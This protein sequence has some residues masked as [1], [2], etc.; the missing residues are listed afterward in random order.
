LVSNIS[1]ERISLE[2]NTPIAEQEKLWKLIK[3]HGNIFKQQ[4]KFEENKNKLKPA[5]IQIQAN[6]QP[7]IERMGQM[8]PG[9]VEL[10]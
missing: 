3:E 2:K 9:E 8:N 5:S 4:I 1:N 7:I 10:F 6:T